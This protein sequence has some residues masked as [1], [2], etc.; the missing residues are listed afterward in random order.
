VSHV[1]GGGWGGVAMRSPPLSLPAQVKMAK[2]LSLAEGSSVTTTVF[3]KS[4]VQEFYTCHFV[5][6]SLDLVR[7]L[8]ILLSAEAYVS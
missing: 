1:N 2:L 4:P 5:V 8:N 6:V 7:T 3:E